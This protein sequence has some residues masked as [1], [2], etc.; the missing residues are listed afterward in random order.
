[1][2]RRRVHPQGCRQVLLLLLLLL[3]LKE[4][5]VV[6]GKLIL[7]QILGELKMEIT[8]EGETPKNR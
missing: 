2:L 1:M 6:G 7:D 8:H 3:L 5:G 4:L